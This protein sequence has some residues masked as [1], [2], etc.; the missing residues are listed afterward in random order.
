[1]R[2]TPLRA[3]PVSRSRRSAFR[4]VILANVAVLLLVLP[5][6]G[7]AAVAPRLRPSPGCALLALAHVDAGNWEIVLLDPLRKQLLNLT[8]SPEDERSPAWSPDGQ[9]IAFA[10]HRE[11]NWDLYTQ[12]L[13]TGALQR[14]TDHPAYDGEP[15]WSPDGRWLAFESNRDGNLEIYLVPRTGGTPRRLT[16]DP[17]AD[18]EPRWTSD[19][20]GL[21]VSSWRS[22]TRQLYRLDLA[23]DQAQALTV[24]GEDAHAAALA[25]DGRSL[26]YLS[27]ASGMAQLLLRDPVAGTTLPLPAGIGTAQEVGWYLDSTRPERGTPALLTLAPHLG[28]PPVYP[29]GWTLSAWAPAWGSTPL[30]SAWTVPLAGQWQHP[31]CAPLGTALPQGAWQPIVQPP[32]IDPA[33][34]P[35]GLLD[36]P[37]VEALQPRL[38]AAV[39]DSFQALRQ[40]L[41]AASGHDFLAVLNDTWRGLDHPQGGILSWHK[42]G[43]AFDVRDWYAPH[44]LRTLYITREDLGGQTYFRLYLRTQQQDGSQGAPLRDSLWETDGRLA[45]PELAQAGG[46]PLPPP[47]GYFVDLTDLAERAG[48]TRIPGLTPPDGDWRQEYLD[49]EF[50]HYERRD[51]LRWYEAMQLL[52]PDAPLQARFTSARLLEHGFAPERLIVAGIP[53]TAPP[54]CVPARDEVPAPC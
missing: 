30:T 25:P 37:E 9:L 45:H 31:V 17:S 51:G 28:T 22:G 19:G 8:R 36:L 13:A 24:P 35:R 2:R 43:R 20:N 11:A 27:S 4:M 12:D 47:D 7:H 32:R 40:Q 14:L 50:W 52:Y 26:A 48:W 38:A 6:R 42:T 46:E 41:L 21:L 23:T 3:A 53:G 39:A 49:L 16:H 1:M 44:G 33:M 5:P 34:L 18:V 29:R 54:P 15:T 10:A